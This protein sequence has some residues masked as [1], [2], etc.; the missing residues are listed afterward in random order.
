MGSCLPME[1]NFRFKELQKRNLLQLFMEGENSGKKVTPEMAAQEIR[2]QL[3]RDYYVTPQQVKSLYSRCIVCTPLFL[4]RGGGLSLQPNFQK[5]VL[6]KTST[7]RGGLLGKTG[8]TFFRGGCNFH[9]KN[10]LKSEIFNNK[11]KQ[12]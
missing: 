12:K 1:K 5:G 9:R 4:R 8:V 2:Q 6:D 11:K 7:F 10:K 3:N